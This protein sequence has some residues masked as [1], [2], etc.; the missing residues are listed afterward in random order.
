MP[1]W[2]YAKAGKQLSKNTKVARKELAARIDPTPRKGR[3]R[4]PWV[5]LVL[6]GLGVAA[7]AALS[8]RPEEIPVAEAWPDQVRARDPERNN[9]VD[10]SD[11]KVTPDTTSERER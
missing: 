8:R 9:S 4:W 1:D 5:V 6:L 11:G 7:A 2:Y 3:R 10:S